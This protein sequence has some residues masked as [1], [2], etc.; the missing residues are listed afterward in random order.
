LSSVKKQEDIVREI[1]RL[2]VNGI[3]LSSA[4][5]SRFLP[6]IGTDFLDIAGNEN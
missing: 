6:D 5:D 1:G 2:S 4:E 3:R